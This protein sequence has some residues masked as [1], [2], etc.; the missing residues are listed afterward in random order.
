MQDGKMSEASALGT[1]SP[2]FLA[3]M[4]ATQGQIPQMPPDS[5]G[6]CMGVDL[7]KPSIATGD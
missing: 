6:I 3:T 7:P 2:P 4:E 1:I 5:G